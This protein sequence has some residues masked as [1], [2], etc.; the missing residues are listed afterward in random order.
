[1]PAAEPISD[2]TADLELVSQAA[3][4]AGE[5]ALRY[6]RRAPKMWTKGLDSPVTEADIAADRFLFD[7]LIGAR[8]AYGWLS[9]ETVD[10]AERLQRQRIFVVDPIDGTRGFIEGNPDWCVS[11]AIVEAGRP[12]VAGLAVPAREEWFVAAAG[13]GAFLNGM[14]L[15]PISE[16]DRLALRNAGPARYMRALADSGFGVL[17]RRVTPSLAY[18]IALVAAGRLD[19]AAASPNAHDW[20]L[21]AADLLVHEAGGLLCAAAGGPVAYNRAEPRHG[22]LVAGAPGL[23]E[24]A[25]PIIAEAERR[26]SGL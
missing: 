9:E 7:R 4:E 23:V 15:A 16:P 5:I 8:P 2:R 22:A 19:V 26:R 18:R 6:F 24:A 3:R 20:D 11:V 14:R 12:V 17:E 1:M 25:G 13:G 21:A 10:T